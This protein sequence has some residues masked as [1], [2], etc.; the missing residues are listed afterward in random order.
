MKSF[1]AGRMIN[2]VKRFCSPVSGKGDFVQ[3]DIIQYVARL[4]TAG[5][6]WRR[7]SRRALWDVAKKLHNEKITKNYIKTRAARFV[8]TLTSAGRRSGCVRIF[9][10]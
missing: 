3:D 8:N 7:I 4:M 2:P 1:S 5:L 6:G 9:N 10:V